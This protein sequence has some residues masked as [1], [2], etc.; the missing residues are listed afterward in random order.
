[1]DSSIDESD[2]GSLSR[3]RTSDEVE[4]EG[5]RGQQSPFLPLFV[6]LLLA[7]FLVHP[8][9]PRLQIQLQ[10]SKHLLVLGREAQTA[11]RSPGELDG[12]ETQPPEAMEHLNCPF[13]LE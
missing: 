4:R 2:L 5:N 13:L 7:A 8:A 1:M 3:R 9:L 12:N 11:L 10:V 6:F